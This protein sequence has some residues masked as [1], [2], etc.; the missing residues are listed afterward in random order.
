MINILTIAHLT[1]SEARRKRI[2]VAALLC[3]LA[4][5]TV[6]GTA[7]A[8]ARSGGIANQ[9]PLQQQLNFAVLTTLGLYAANFLS[10][11]FAVLLPVDT[12]SGDIDSGVMQTLASKPVRRAEIVL[13][14]CLGHWLIVVSYMLLLCSMVMAVT[15][16]AGRTVRIGFLDA[17]PL[18]VLE[19]TVMLSV[20]IA[21][22]TRFTTVTNGVVALGVYGVAFIGGWM[23][24]IGT[25]IRLDGVRMVGVAASLFSPADAMWRRGVFLMQP[26]I[27]RGTQLLGPFSTPSVANALMIW[28]AMAFTM[29]MLV[30]AIRSFGR[31]PL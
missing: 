22:G 20:T 19:L 3:G 9:A 28:W 29:V 23:E 26:S 25:V 27:I 2:L 13:G 4:Y 7:V 1:I 30:I 8:F 5:L 10:V 17:L 12:L 31:R 15:W 6:F 21:G 18:L 16:L 24:Q 14:K 11:L